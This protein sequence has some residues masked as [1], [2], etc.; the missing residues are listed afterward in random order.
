MENT[1]DWRNEVAS[2]VDH[3]RVRR[4]RPP[5]ERSMTLAF[6]RPQ[7]PWTEETG[8]GVTET[9]IP[10]ALRNLPLELPDPA[11]QL[12]S[13][14]HEQGIQASALAQQDTPPLQHEPEDDNVIPFPRS[15]IFPVVIEELAEPVLDRPRILDVP[16]APHASSQLLLAD[17]GLSTLSNCD[18]SQGLGLDLPLHAAGLVRR[19]SAGFLDALVV[20]SA[21]I[22][23]WQVAAQAKVELPQGKL[24]MATVLVL[25]GLLWA[26]YQYIF[27]VVGGRTAGM[28]A[29]GLRLATF[30]PGRVTRSSRCWRVLGMMFSS[31]PLGLGVAWALFDEDALCWHD[32][33]SRTY[34]SREVGSGAVRG[35]ECRGQ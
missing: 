30:D 14:S 34:L 33:I 16:E 13:E 11:Q 25:L 8:P 26:I 28:Q 1:V 17:V 2:R 6:D 22:V 21:G 35:T 27:L 18:E 23:F 3:Y 12:Q 5:R 19:V 32:R 31:F 10:A 4:K 20:L 29:L 24:G 15:A 9:H 7:A